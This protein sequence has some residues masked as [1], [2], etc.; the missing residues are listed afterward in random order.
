MFICKTITEQGEEDTMLKRLSDLVKYLKGELIVLKIER[1]TLVVD[2][3]NFE[4]ERLQDVATMFFKQTY[5][6]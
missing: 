3:E 1:N 6:L 4:K 2:A 5:N